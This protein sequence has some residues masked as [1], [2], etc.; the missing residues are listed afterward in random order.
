[1]AG[2][3]LE[4]GIELIR[5]HLILRQ[6]KA[7]AESQEAEENGFVR[8]PSVD[9][10][11]WVDV[12][13]LL[14]VDNFDDTHDDLLF[15]VRAS[16]EQNE[17]PIFVARHSSSR[18]PDLGDVSV[19]WEETVYLNMVLHCFTYLVT[20]VVGRRPLMGGSMQHLYK[21]HKRVFPSPSRTRMDTDKATITEITYPHVFFPIEDFEDCF[22]DVV[23]QEGETV[24]VEMVASSPLGRT[25]IFQGSVPYTAL[26]QAYHT[27]KTNNK[28]WEI[29]FMRTERKTEFLK[30]RGPRGVGQAQMAVSMLEEEPPPSPQPTGAVRRLFSATLD[31]FGGS[32]PGAGPKPLNAS[33][34]FI[35]TRVRHAVEILLNPS[36]VAPILDPTGKDG[37]VG[38]NSGN[39][40]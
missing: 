36:P 4:K 22:K 17:E 35:S 10:S 8:V 24:C 5:E 31:M 15:F 40:A 18:L 23:C 34:T 21:T 37:L 19:N 28:Q 3:A 6:A 39:I 25:A 14:F 20:V 29:P 26:L 2:S 9:L 33:L 16:R 12:Y 32:G 7:K 13:R 38:V 11:F 30:L 1:M 27:K